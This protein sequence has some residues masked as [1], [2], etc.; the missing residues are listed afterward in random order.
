M[1]R[2]WP[3]IEPGAPYIHG[4]HI[5]AVGAHLEAVTAGEITRLLINVPPGTMKSLL[6]GVFWPAWEWGPKNRPAYAPSRSRIPSV[7]RSATTCARGA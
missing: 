4:W 3:V 1:R 6:A 7:W 5:D 2:A